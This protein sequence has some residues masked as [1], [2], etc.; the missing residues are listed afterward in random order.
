MLSLVPASPVPVP[1]PR[2]EVLGGDGL[3][4][5]LGP[6]DG[7]RVLVLGGG[8]LELT[9]G[10]IRRGCPGV[11]LLRRGERP[12]AAEHDLVLVP[13]VSG[14]ECLDALVLRVRRALAPG[15]GLAA[16]LGGA[17]AGSRAR[18]LALRL[19]LNGFGRVRAASRGGAVLVR[20][21]LPAPGPAGAA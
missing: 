21:S 18:G 6:L 8:G 10:L 13:L 9:G 17:A 4:D 14:E 16:V 20:A 7:S 1:F 11:T 3:L 19:R 12:P 2:E 5:R 15:G